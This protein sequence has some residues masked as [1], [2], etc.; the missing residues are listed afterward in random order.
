MPSKVESEVN[1]VVQFVKLKYLENRFECPEIPKDEMCHFNGKTYF[2]GQNLI[3][4][5][6]PACLRSCV[7]AL[8]YPE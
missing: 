5:D 4:K 8:D 6:Q 1:L 7:C 2:Q 3:E